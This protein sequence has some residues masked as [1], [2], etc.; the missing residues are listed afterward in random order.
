MRGKRA[1]ELRRAALEFCRVNEV[2]KMRGVW[3][4]GYRRNPWTG[5]IMGGVVRRIYRVFKRQWARTGKIPE[6]GFL[7]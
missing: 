1:R 7:K 2:D 5:A 3:I 6:I 4:S